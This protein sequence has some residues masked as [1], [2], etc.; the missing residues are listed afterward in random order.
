MCLGSFFLITPCILSFFFC[1]GGM[2]WLWKACLLFFVCLVLFFSAM[3]NLWIN[4]CCLFKKG[5]FWKFWENW[6][7]FGVLSQLFQAYRI[8]PH[9]LISCAPMGLLRSLLLGFVVWFILLLR[10]STRSLGTSIFYSDRKLTPHAYV[11]PH[12]GCVVGTVY[13]SFA[14]GLVGRHA[15]WALLPWGTGGTAPN[16][17][18]PLV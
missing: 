12:F 14:T 4:C 7:V 5:V 10:F 18:T 3:K 9:K 11:H 2:P 6:E 16:T 17:L 1:R 15:C 13:F 8:Q